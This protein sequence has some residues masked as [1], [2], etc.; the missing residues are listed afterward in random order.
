[1]AVVQSC[2]GLWG[3]SVSAFRFVYSCVFVCLCVCVE[4]RFKASVIKARESACFPMPSWL[5]SKPF[6]PAHWL[7]SGILCLNGSKALGFR[8]CVY[9][10]ACRKGCVV[11]GFPPWCQCCFPAGVCGPWSGGRFFSQVDW[12]KWHW[13]KTEG[14]MWTT[15]H[16]LFYQLLK[17]QSRKQQILWILVA[18]TEANAGICEVT[19]EKVQC[20]NAV[21]EWVSEFRFSCRWGQ[22]KITVSQRIQ[23]TPSLSSPCVE[24]STSL[25]GYSHVTTFLSLKQESVSIRESLTCGYL[26]EK[27]DAHTHRVSCLH[28]TSLCL[29][30]LPS[31][32]ARRL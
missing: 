12:W 21:S 1:M 29:P 11:A 13:F 28:L 2:L 31:L 9:I 10:C 30:C 16:G 18:D 6:L 20:I 5:H 15:S 7:L 8:A 24:L 19:E 27:N 17:H 14:T 26:P 22:R 4:E 32:T 25:D 3:E 23:K